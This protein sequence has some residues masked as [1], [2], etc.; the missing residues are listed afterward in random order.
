[1]APLHGIGRPDRAGCCCIDEGEGKK[2]GKRQITGENAVVS[3]NRGELENVL[4]RKKQFK[5]LREV[6]TE[7]NRKRG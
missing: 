3:A 1:M 5:V 7:S 6:W 4:V 2:R